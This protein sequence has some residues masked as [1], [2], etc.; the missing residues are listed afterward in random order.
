MAQIYSPNFVYFTVE[1]V[2]VFY[3]LTW[4]EYQFPNPSIDLRLR[5]NT[6]VLVIESLTDLSHTVQFRTEIFQFHSRLSLNWQTWMIRTEHEV[7]I[8]KILGLAM[9]FSEVLATR[10]KGDRH[11]IKK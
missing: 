4:L 1:A 7:S 9:K 5:I 11:E 2:I 3:R 8:Q 6:Y 10:S